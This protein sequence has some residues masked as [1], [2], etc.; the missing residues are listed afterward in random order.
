MTCFGIW[1]LRNEPLLLSF[2]SDWEYVIYMLLKRLVTFNWA[3]WCITGHHFWTKKP[4]WANLQNVSK[5]WDSWLL[6][7]WKLANVIKHIMIKNYN[8]TTYDINVRKHFLCWRLTLLYC[9]LF[10]R[11]I[12]LS[13]K[14]RI[15][16]VLS[17]LKA[18]RNLVKKY[19]ISKR[20]IQQIHGLS[21]F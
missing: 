9:G 20:M 13:N 14:G 10:S 17:F 6:W 1:S 15:L 11:Q 5:I 3:K 19:C 8:K 2:T 7:N 12:H 21:H 16:E 18:L 4:K